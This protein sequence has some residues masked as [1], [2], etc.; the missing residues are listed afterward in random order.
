ML[1]HFVVVIANFFAPPQIGWLMNA[2][3]CLSLSILILIAQPYRKKYMNMLDGL[4]LALIGSLTLLIV[5]FQF[6][7]PSANE[8]MPFMIVIAC[9]FA[10]LVLLLS[11]TYACTIVERKADSAIYCKHGQ[12]IVNSYSQTKPSRR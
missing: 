3:V 7:L 10:Q 8:A 4:L 12:H 2:V 6:L 9:S 5:I 11:V 1:F